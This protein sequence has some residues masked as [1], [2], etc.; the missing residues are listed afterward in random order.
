MVDLPK[1][2]NMNYSHA[3]QDCTEKQL[4]DKQFAELKMNVGGGGGDGG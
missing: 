3:A 4:Q 1:V 2:H